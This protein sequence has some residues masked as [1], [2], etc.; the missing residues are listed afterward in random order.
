[1]NISYRK[2]LLLHLKQYILKIII[3]V[4]SKLKNSDEGKGDVDQLSISRWL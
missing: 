1:M 2:L 4:N 3:D